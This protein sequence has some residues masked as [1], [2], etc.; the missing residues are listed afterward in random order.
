VHYIPLHLMTYYKKRY[1][2]TDNQFPNAFRNFTRS[3]SLPLYPGLTD[4][5]VER[6]IGTVIR[7]GRKH[8][9]CAGAR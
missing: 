8:Y 3:F 5:E 1:G 6:V 9:A 7:T 4:D 2:F